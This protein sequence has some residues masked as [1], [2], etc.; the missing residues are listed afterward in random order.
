MKVAFILSMPGVN[1]WN[2]I[3]SGAGKLYAKVLSVSDAKKTKEKYFKIA[4]NGPYYH[5]WNDGWT[6]CITVKIIDT[7]EAKNIRKNSHGFCG[8]DW[9]ID[10]IRDFGQTEAPIVKNN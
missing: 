5:Y 7:V 3:W 1:S 10:N 2:G 8:Y 6:A 4:Q 9:M